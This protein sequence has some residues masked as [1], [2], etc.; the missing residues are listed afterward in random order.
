MHSFLR[1]SLP[2]QILALSKAFKYVRATHNPPSPK[3]TSSHL[4]SRSYLLLEAGPLSTPHSIV[5]SHSLLLKMRPAAP[6]VITTS[7]QRQALHVRIFKAIFAYLALILGL[8]G[9]VFS[10]CFDSPTTKTIAF[11]LSGCS[12]LAQLLVSW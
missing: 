9:L 11:S 4:S 8:L 6:T 10:N 7:P 1:G 2:W 5:F 3:P 12:L